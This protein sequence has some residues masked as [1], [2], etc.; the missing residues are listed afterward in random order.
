VRQSHTNVGTET[1]GFRPA[2]RP[3]TPPEAV[4]LRS[5]ALGLFVEGFKL[6]VEKLHFRAVFCVVATQ[7]IQ[8]LVDGEL[9]NYSHH[10]IL[11][12]A[13]EQGKW[14]LERAAGIFDFHVFDVRQYPGEVVVV[15][16]LENEVHILGHD[17]GRACRGEVEII[18]VLLS[19]SDRASGG[20]SPDPIS[21]DEEAGSVEVRKL[22][23]FDGVAVL[24]EHQLAEIS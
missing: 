13:H 14:G 15:D 2:F 16:H 18:A 4:F 8:H 17:A 11:R 7:F 12:D 1:L 22:S 23:K 9:V 21:L 3:S 20:F 10:K 19:R 24:R 6:V 5:Q